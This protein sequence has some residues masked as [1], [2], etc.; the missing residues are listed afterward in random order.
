M[1]IDG[2]YA[3]LRALAFVA[4]FQACGSALFLMFFGQML[5][6]SHGVLTRLNTMA[7][8][9]AIGC[10]L[11]LHLLEAARMADSLEGLFDGALQ[12]VVLE[13]SLAVALAWRLAG[14]VFILTGLCAS[15]T[16]SQVWILSGVVLA[17]SSFTFVGHTV[18]HPARGL[19]SLALFAHAYMVA[20]WFGGLLPLWLIRLHE[21]QALAAQV[22]R[23]YSML[24]VKL[25]PVLFLAGMLLT[26]GL[27]QSFADL[28]SPYGLLLLAKLGGFLLLLALASINR[29]R[30]V[31]AIERGVLHATVNLRK[32]LS[33]EYILII[34]IFI[35]TAVLTTF[36]SPP[37][38]FDVD[39]D[40]GDDD[41]PDAL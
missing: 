2:L 37:A 9:V 32:T 31:P 16:A 14:L 22:T 11:V 26:V 27:L 13:S 21:S 39:V 34:L 12:T 10:L 25:V 40:A 18:D 6:V 23:R 7:A 41:D 3:G 24:A 36:T 38:D 35:A 19:L 29:W 15:S 4:L 1:T 20:F 5:A 8:G 28:M 33:A 30:L 17:M